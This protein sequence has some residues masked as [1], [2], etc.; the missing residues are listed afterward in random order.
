[1]PLQLIIS[2]LLYYDLRI[3]GEGYD[4]EMLAQRGLDGERVSG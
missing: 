2:T 3:R 4:L 1:M